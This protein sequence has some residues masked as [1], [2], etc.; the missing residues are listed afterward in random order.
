MLFEPGLL[1][2]EPKF[3]IQKPNVGNDT[4]S[5]TGNHISDKGHLTQKMLTLKFSKYGEY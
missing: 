4:N 5:A 3:S 1:N 2:F